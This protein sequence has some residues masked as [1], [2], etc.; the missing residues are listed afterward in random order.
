M[1]GQRRPRR[2]R[3]TPPRAVAEG[4]AAMSSE[5]RG[6]ECDPH[7]ELHHDGPGIT[8]V[9]ILHDDWCPAIGG[10]GKPA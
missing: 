6:C 8:R 2:G 1:S 3:Y 7:V 4:F 9:S 5:A 10:T